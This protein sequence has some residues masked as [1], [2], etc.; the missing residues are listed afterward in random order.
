MVIVN[1]CP[2]GR[3]LP[4]PRTTDVPSMTA[5]SLRSNCG[6]TRAR[7]PAFFAITTICCRAAGKGCTSSTVPP[8]T[9]Y[10]AA[11]WMAVVPGGNGPATVTTR[12]LLLA[13]G[14]DPW[15]TVV[16]TAAEGSVKTNGLSGFTGEA[17]LFTI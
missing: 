3:S 10:S 15:M 4:M 14:D 16:P 1:G 13:S 7:E 9:G 17:P 2:A 8:P 5:S 11:T 12:P 6:D